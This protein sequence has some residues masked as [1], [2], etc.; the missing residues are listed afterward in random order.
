[1]TKGHELEHLIGCYFHEDWI[2][3]GDTPDEILH[4]YLW[5]NYLEVIHALIIEIDELLAGPMTEQQ[6]SELISVK[7]YC[8][9]NFRSDWPSAREWLKHVRKY[10]ADHAPS[11]AKLQ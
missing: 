5:D 10:L 9:Y 1:M 6:I 2:E 7:Y 8:C 3:D 11:L 4:L